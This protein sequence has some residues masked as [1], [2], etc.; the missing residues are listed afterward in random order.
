MRR[1][2]Y[3]DPFYVSGNKMKVMLHWD[4]RTRMTLVFSF[5]GEKVININRFQQIGFVLE[6]LRKQDVDLMMTKNEFINLHFD[7]KIN[8]VDFQIEDIIF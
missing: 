4:V 3:I 5:P 7:K 2:L 8:R 6:F 1:Q